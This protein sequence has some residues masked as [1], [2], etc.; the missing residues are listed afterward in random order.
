MNGAQQFMQT[1]PLMVG[2]PPGIL[3]QQML[4]FNID[5]DPFTA[6]GL[7]GGPQPCV[8]TIDHTNQSQLTGYW[9]EYAEDRAFRLTLGQGVDYMFTAG[10][11]GCSFLVRDSGTTG[12]VVCHSNLASVGGVIG[13]HLGGVGLGRAAIS[14]KGLQKLAGE[15]LLG[16]GNIVT[17]HSFSGYLTTVVGFKD[18]NNIWTFARQINLVNDLATAITLQSCDFF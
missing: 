16:G 3:G 4:H 14:Q 5:D 9:C 15:V 17:R 12:P 1:V 11:S 6:N 7:P 8:L 10:M 2:I 13:Q 18:G